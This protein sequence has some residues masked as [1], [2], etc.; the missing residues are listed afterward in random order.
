ME[1]TKYISNRDILSKSLNAKPATIL[2]FDYK[3]QGQIRRQGRF[4]HTHEYEW[5]KPRA[6]LEQSIFSLF[7]VCLESGAPREAVAL[8]IPIASVCKLMRSG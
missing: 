7:V 4:P 1:A 3:Y 8:C 2:F 6:I 5:C